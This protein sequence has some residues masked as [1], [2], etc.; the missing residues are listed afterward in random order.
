MAAAPPLASPPWE[1]SV[2]TRWIEPVAGPLAIAGAGSRWTGARGISTGW[3]DR[4]TGAGCAAGDNGTAVTRGC[5]GTPIGMGA[6]G[7]GDGPPECE[8]EAGVGG[9]ATAR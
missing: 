8:A 7:A 4:N 5:D 1:G 9:A 6:D 3:A 2:S